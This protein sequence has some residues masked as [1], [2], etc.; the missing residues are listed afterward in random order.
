MAASGSGLIMKSITLEN[1]AGA[2]GGPRCWSRAH[3][4]VPLL[5]HRK[6]GHNVCPLHSNRQFVNFIFGNA[7]VA[8]QNCTPC[9]MVNT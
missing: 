1:Y 2:S 6:L 7:A 3:S 5:H 9:T 8:Y 4:G